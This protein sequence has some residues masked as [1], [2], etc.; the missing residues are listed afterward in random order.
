M[1]AGQHGIHLHSVGRCDAPGFQTAGPH[2]NPTNRQHGLRKGAGRGRSAAAERL[3]LRPRR[4]GRP[5]RLDLKGRD[6]MRILMIAPEPFFEK[7]PVREKLPAGQS[8]AQLRLIDEAFIQVVLV[9]NFAFRAFFH[10]R[11][12][13]AFYKKSSKSR[14]AGAFSF[15]KFID[16][17]SIFVLL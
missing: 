3:A 13:F 9:T 7:I 12:I 5:D 14:T 1:P 8:R 11:F 17:L 6:R 15:A 2:L 16:R 10:F 4:R